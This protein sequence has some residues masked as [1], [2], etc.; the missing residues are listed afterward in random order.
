MTGQWG[1]GPA[2]HRRRWPLVL[3]AVVAALAAAAVT[4][5]V[6]LHT[7]PPADEGRPQAA[8]ES[9]T[10]SVGALPGAAD[11]SRQTCA[12]YARASDSMRAAVAAVAGL[13]PGMAV[14]DTAARSDPR[15]SPA[16]AASLER[17]RAAAATLRDGIAAGTPPPL[18]DTAAALAA[19]LDALVAAD[20]A[21][22]AATA[23]DA[24]A[25]ASAAD[26]ATATLCERQR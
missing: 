25:A 10:T 19:A 11:A 23:G 20:Q 22:D 26:R 15:W 14:T 13:P 9:P 18:S 2:A 7:R 8:A 16:V 17:Y 24:F 4:A 21:G 5:A 3:V 1:A 12:A 6:L